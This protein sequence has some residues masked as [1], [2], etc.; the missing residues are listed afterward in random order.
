MT[1]QLAI[2]LL[3]T[4]VVALLQ[5]SQAFS[6]D[7]DPTWHGKKS[8]DHNCQHVG[9]DPDNRCHWFDSAQVTAEEACPRS[10]NPACS[11]VLLA[12]TPLQVE[13]CEDSATWAAE[14]NP[15]HNCAYVGQHPDYRCDW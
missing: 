6:C 11:V 13:S 1:D 15:E 12:P 9:E 5:T 7:D 10:C 3:I 8:V 2:R 4:I 14:L